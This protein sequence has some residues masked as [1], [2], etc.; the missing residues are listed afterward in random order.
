M[1]IVINEFGRTDVDGFCNNRWE[2]TPEWSLTSKLLIS[3]HQ[4]VQ[5]LEAASVL[6][7]MN[8][9]NTPPLSAKDFQ[10]DQEESSASPAASGYSDMRDS[11]DSSAYTTPPPQ[12]EGQDDHANR[13]SSGSGFSR[14][15][16]SAPSTHSAFSSS[17]PSSYGFS[18]Y[19]QGSERS[20]ISPSLTAISTGNK[21]EDES[22]ANAI[23]VLSCGFG[24]PQ[25]RVTTMPVDVPPVPPLPPQYASYAQ[26]YT[27]PSQHGFSGSTEAPISSSYQPWGADSYAASERYHISDD[28]SQADV[29]MEDGVDSPMDEDD[30][31]QRYRGRSDEDD[32]GVF[33]RMEE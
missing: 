22:L 6:V 21:E 7:G 14:S 24:T 30:D 12:A 17:M 13:Y 31:E 9:D 18:H 29:K 23:G 16:Q 15:Y 33:G 1:P 10:S 2:H 19:Q 3:K 28:R 25:S 8:I 27:A 5:L 32:E 20:V 4:Q 11:R 26:Q